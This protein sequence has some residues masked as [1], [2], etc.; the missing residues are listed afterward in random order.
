[1]DDLRKISTIRCIKDFVLKNQ[2]YSIAAILRDRERLIIKLDK[3]AKGVKVRTTIE[4]IDEYLYGISIIEKLE[5]GCSYTLP[6]HFV[7][8]PEENKI[9]I[10][11]F[12]NE[13][14]GGI[15]FKI[16]SRNEKINEILK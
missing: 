8:E 7:G 5:A 12:L 14:N 9:K 6:R 2:M 13:T 1:M 4:Y 15:L 10:M 3:F 11:K 16:E